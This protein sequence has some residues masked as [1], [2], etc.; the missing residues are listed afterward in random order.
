MK[1]I[2]GF[3]LI[4][5]MIAM[6]LGIIVVSSV[7]SIYISSIRSS[8]DITN[9]ARL[10]YDLDSVAQLMLNDIRRAGSWGGAIAGSDANDN[11]FSDT[12]T[13]SNV[14]IP[15]ST[16]ILYTYDGDGD[17]SMVNDPADPNDD[18]DE[19]YGFKLDGGAIKISSA[20]T[21]DDTGDC[22]KT[23]NRWETITDSNK[24]NVSSLSFSM[25]NSQ[26]SNVTTSEVYVDVTAPIDT[27]CAAAIAA[28]AGV[29]GK[30]SSGD[31]AVETQQ[32]DIVLQGNVVGDTPVTKSLTT[33]VKIRNDRVFTQP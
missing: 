31:K 3:T 26:C 19:Y 11:P 27:S 32:I 10:N 17:G 7:F 5:I 21:V 20:D 33:I 9:S 28:A 16:C 29:T 18:D 30:V 14:Q 4:E 2:Q 25:A 24:V 23:D 1:K 12:A 8:T 15:V 22:T 13:N 6:L